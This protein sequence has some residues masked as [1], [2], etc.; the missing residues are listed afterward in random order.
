MGDKGINPVEYLLAGLVKCV[1]TSLVIHAK[2]RGVNIDSI[3]STLEGDTD[4]HG[5]FQ[6]DD[7]NP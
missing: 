4:L 7:T 1:N 6:L 5:L 3:E 2:V